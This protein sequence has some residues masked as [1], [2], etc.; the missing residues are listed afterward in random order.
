[1]EGV[2]TLSASYVSFPR[3]QL[4]EL[5][6]LLDARCEVLAKENLYVRCEN[7]KKLMQKKLVYEIGEG[8]I[9]LEMKELV[10]KSKGHS[11]LLNIRENDPDNPYLILG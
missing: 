9:A 1:M 5:I 8:R 6:K 10:L 3:R 11:V 2:F 7:G 4:G